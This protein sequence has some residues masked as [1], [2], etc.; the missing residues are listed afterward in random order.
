MSINIFEESDMI[1]DLDFKQRSLLFAKI[2]QLVYSDD[3]KAV[4]KEALKLGFKEIEFYNTMVHKH[5]VY[6]MM[7]IW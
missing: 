4:K 3:V 6:K 7:Q 5:I 2:A 1:I